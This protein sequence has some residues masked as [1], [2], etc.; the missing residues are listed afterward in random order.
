MQDYSLRVIPFALLITVAHLLTIAGA[1][2]DDRAYENA[3]DLSA[4][5]ILPGDLLQNE[6]HTVADRVRNDGY[7]NYYTIKSDY[8]E[9]EADSTATLRIRISEINALAELDA[10]SQTEV[11]IKAAADAGVGQLKSIKQLV[12]Q[13]VETVVGIPSGIGRMF[14]RYLRQAGEAVDA[15]KEFVDADDA[16]QTN[17]EK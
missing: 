6:H 16:E 8:G 12:T 9:F 14:K 3:K 11:F 2:A 7:L 4:A 1:I 13:P 10:L 17:G 5:D 15:T